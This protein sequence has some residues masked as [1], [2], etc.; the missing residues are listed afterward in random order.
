MKRILKDNVGWSQSY[1]SNEDAISS[2]PTYNCTWSQSWSSDWSD[3]MCWSENICYSEEL[4][5]NEM[6]YPGGSS[7][8]GFNWD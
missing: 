2:S 7:C 5:E 1:N 8:F 4:S 3:R 6:M